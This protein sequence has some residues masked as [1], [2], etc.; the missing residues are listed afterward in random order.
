MDLFFACAPSNISW[1]VIAV[2]IHSVNCVLRGWGWTNISKE[3]GKTIKPFLANLDSATTVV[4]PTCVGRIH[5]TRDHGVPSAVFL[6][7][8]GLSVNAVVDVGFFVRF[9]FEQFSNLFLSEAATRLST[10]RGQRILREPSFGSAL[11]SAKPSAYGTALRIGF[12]FPWSDNSEP[13]EFLAC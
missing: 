7:F 11:T 13:S 6:K 3:R 5:A 2:V 12:R 9:S 8:I 10:S 1:L 4:F